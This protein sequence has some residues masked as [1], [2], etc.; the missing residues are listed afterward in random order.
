VQL[1]QNQQSMISILFED[2]RVGYQTFGAIGLGT[3]GLCIANTLKTD[4]TWDWKTFGTSNGFDASLIKTGI[5]KDLNSK[6]LLNLNDGNASVITQPIGTN[7]TQIANTAFV[8]NA[9]ANLVDSS[10]S[11]LNTLNELAQALG[12]DPNFATTIM[13][14]LSLKADNT[15]NNRTTTDKT[16]TGAINE[17][18]ARQNIIVD[19]ITTAITVGT[20]SITLTINGLGTNPIVATNGDYSLNTAQVLGITN[21]D[22]DTIIVYY[23]NGVEGNCKFNFT[24][25]TN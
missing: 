5:L 10:P 14:M 4:G 17:L 7:T 24:Y 11:T 1:N 20:G 15:D 3:K 25:K 6:F 18:N 22:I 23:T 8:S 16:V 19:T 21:T 12:D 9:I 13:N 2:R